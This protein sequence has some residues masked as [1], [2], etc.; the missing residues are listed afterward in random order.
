MSIACITEALTGVTAGDAV[1]V[2]GYSGTTPIVATATPTK[3]GT[4]RTV[5]GVA[6][7][8]AG[9]GGVAVTVLSAGEVAKQALTGLSNGGLSSVTTVDGSGRLTP[10]VRPNGSEFIVGTCDANGHTSVQPRASL[11]TSPQHVFNVRAYGAVS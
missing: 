6:A 11:D 3:L 7:A 9:S 10:L 4:S 8:T 2:T 5:L 1:C